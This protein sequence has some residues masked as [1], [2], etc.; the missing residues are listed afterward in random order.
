MAAT[1]RLHRYWT[2]GAGGQR[3]AWGT[4]GD[5]DRCVA[6]LERHMPGKAEGYCNLLHKRATGMYPAEHAKLLRGGKDKGGG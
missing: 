5:F 3:I 2:T 6:E 4:A 1:E